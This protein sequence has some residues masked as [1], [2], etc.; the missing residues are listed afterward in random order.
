MISSIHSIYKLL[1][2]HLTRMYAIVGSVILRFHCALKKVLEIYM[3]SKKAK[4]SNF[5]VSGDDFIPLFTSGEFTPESQTVPLTF[6]VET[7]GD[8]VVEQDEVVQ[9][10]LRSSDA[11]VNIPSDAEITTVIITDNDCKQE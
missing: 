6:V 1:G 10:Q 8:A 4:M 7:V 11:S 2:V 9:I 5:T 3:T